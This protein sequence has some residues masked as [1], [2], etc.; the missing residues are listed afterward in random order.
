VCGHITSTSASEF[1]N[2]FLHPDRG[3]K[4]TH[5]LFLYLEC[6]DQDLK[7]V[8]GAFSTRV[9]YIVGSMLN[10]KDLL[11]AKI[12]SCSACFIIACKHCETKLRRTM[13][14]S[15][16]WCPSNKKDPCYPTAAAQLQQTT[17]I[18]H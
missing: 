3:D 4:Y 5:V 2:N 10:R 9:Q 17:C 15:W 12:N 7:I 8:P 11:L 18:Q 1:L 13:S 6:P 14:V 16:G